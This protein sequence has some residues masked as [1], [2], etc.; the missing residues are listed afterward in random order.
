[1]KLHA[2]QFIAKNEFGWESEKISFGDNITQFSGEN[3]SGKTPIV[4]SI[5]YCLGYP[6]SFREDVAARCK[7]ARL[8]LSAKGINYTFERTIENDFSIAV[9]NLE[10]GVA[11]YDNERSFSKFFFSL[12]DLDPVGLLDTSNRRT[13]PYTS[14]VLPLF[15]LDQ[16]IGYSDIYKPSTNTFIKD[17][18]QEMVRYVFNFSQKNL[19]ES[20]KDKIQ[21]KT[22]RDSLDELIASQRAALN[23]ILAARTSTL[24]E[25]EISAQIKDKNDR[26]DRIRR[27]KSGRSD[28]LSGFDS[29]IYEVE[30]SISNLSQEENDLDLRVSSFSTIR[31]EIQIEA[32]TLSLNERAKRLFEIGSNV[33]TRPE[34]GLFERSNESYA[35]SLLYLKDQVKDIESALDA[36]L[37]RTS[38]VKQTKLH[39]QQQLQR[40]RSKRD[41]AIESEGISGV[42]DAVGELTESIVRLESDLSLAQRTKALVERLDITSQER[43]RANDSIDNLERRNRG[44]DHSMAELRSQ[45][46]PLT[47]KWLD[48]L[49][50]ENF[51]RGILI[52]ND[53][54]FQFG[55]DQLRAFK[56][57][58]LVRIILAIHAAL[59]EAYISRPGLRMSFMIFDTPNQQEISVEDLH[60]FMMRLKDLCVRHKAQVLFSSKDYH[61]SALEEADKFIAPKYPGE[62]HSMYLGKP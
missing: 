8:W 47:L 2:V 50:T 19:F 15:F 4:Q 11:F 40:L 30:R 59:F 53:L 42:V 45:L 20:E 51:D 55:K 5:V 6:V 13:V 24:S 3:G 37:Q 38:V 21:L 29:A 14:T 43:T 58:T 46:I 62:K 1:M 18:F 41:Q 33:C 22:R 28:V 26:L 36:A 39:L 9:T 35:K 57:S 49:G 56:G 54:K 34:C 7:S 25:V 48:I 27:S 60:R 52:N 17:Q 16:D 44:G 12:I 61:Y 23:Q 31:N 10:G 32:N